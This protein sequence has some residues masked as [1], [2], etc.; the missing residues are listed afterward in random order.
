MLVGAKMRSGGSQR[1]PQDDIAALV[2]AGHVDLQAREGRAR[3]SVVGDAG[4]NNFP[5]RAAAY[6]W[7][8][9]RGGKRERD[10]DA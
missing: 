4:P 3:Q 6:C 7:A 1:R 2:P 9:C 5:K 8:G 10:G